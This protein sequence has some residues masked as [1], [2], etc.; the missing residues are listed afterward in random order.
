[1]T[2]TTDEDV[3]GA[4]GAFL[5]QRGYEVLLVREHFGTETP[6]HVIARA[7]SERTALV[8]TFNRRHFLALAK[9]RRMNRTLSYPGMSVVSFNLR[10]PQGLARLQALIDDVEAV[11]ANRVARGG[12]MIA[13]IGDTVPRFEDPEGQRQPR[14]PSARRPGGSLPS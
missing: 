5:S 9:R 12:R 7:A 1:M 4:I 3:P 11:H 13:V 8:Y 10:R 2:V 14:R 6:D